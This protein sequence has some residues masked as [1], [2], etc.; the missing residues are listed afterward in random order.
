[1]RAN[2]H[3]TN[4]FQ[5]I[6]LRPFS[7]SKNAFFRVVFLFVTTLIIGFQST[8][9]RAQELGL[10]VS[11]EVGKVQWTPN[12]PDSNLSMLHVLGIETLIFPLEILSEG[13]TL[14]TLANQWDGNLVI[15][16]GV[17]FLDAYKLERQ[18]DSLLNHYASGMMLARQQPSITG[19][20]MHRFSPFQDSLFSQRWARITKTLKQFNPG[21]LFYVVPE[22]KGNT[23]PSFT[24]DSTL[25]HWVSMAYVFDSPFKWDDL[26]Q[27]EK[28]FRSNSDAQV[29]WFTSTWLDE[30][31]LAHP[32]LEQSFVFWNDTG[33]FMLA[34]P[35]E[36]LGQVSTHWSKPF[37]VV[38]ILFFSGLYQQSQVYRQT[39]TRYFTNYSF[40]IDDMLR[41]SERYAPI[42]LLLFVIRAGIVSLSCVIW[43]LSNGTALDWAYLGHFLVGQ[44]KLIPNTFLFWGLLSFI[45]LATQFAELLI[46]RIPKSGFRT[47]RQIFVVY[48]WNIHL[49]LILLLLIFIAFVNQFSI[50]YGIT[51]LYLVILTWWIGFV[52]SAIQGTKE[53]FR[54]GERYLFW[55]LGIYT[56]LVGLSTY[57][58]SQ[59]ESAQGIM[60]MFLAL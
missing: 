58:I 12:N 46:L 14:S 18:Q 54:G 4:F 59:S 38:L 55:S 47:M 3:F 49:N 31:F 16:Y 44:T 26:E 6:K 10:W 45:L 57:T 33:D 27:L 48:S 35:A 23:S 40:L 60:S 29:I 8:S 56:L 20:L 11:Y 41:Y 32:S 34:E 51:I 30:A 13:N 52:L 7:F 28:A 53:T 21:E 2:L 5:L 43:G 50:V 19:H 15:D 22:F 36:K 42:G 37:M 9:S 17:Q 24:A 39:P 1:M 25:T